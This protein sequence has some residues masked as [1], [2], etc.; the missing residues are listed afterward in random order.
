ME[1]TEI[2]K[3]GELQEA[4]ATHR[5]GDKVSIT[6][7]RNKTKHTTTVE[8]KNAQGNTKT[9]SKLN[10]D[11]LGVALEAISDKDKQALSLNYGLVVKHLREGKMKQAG[12]TKGL[13]L[14]QV[15]DK[16][17]KTLADWE[18][19]IKE[20]NLSTDRVLW[21]RA[22]TQSGLNKSFTVELDER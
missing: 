12:I 15:N 1:T 13:I 19:A 16:P 2:T 8:L 11:H 10:T 20:A 7:L 21:I 14:M 22:K 4:L 17:L 3:S 6:Y 5:P 9:L 18:E